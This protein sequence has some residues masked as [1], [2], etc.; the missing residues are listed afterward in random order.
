MFELTVSPLNKLS[1][2]EFLICFK[3]Q[4]ASILLKVVKMLSECQTAW[5]L[6]RRRVTRRLIKI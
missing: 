6:A 3:F 2:A 1:S 4:S 5:I